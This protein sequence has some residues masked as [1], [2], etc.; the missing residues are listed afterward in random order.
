MLLRLETRPRQLR[1]CHDDHLLGRL[2]RPEQ[3][4]LPL[5]LGDL[6]L[7]AGVGELRLHRRQGLRLSEEPHFF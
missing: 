7:D 4:G 1:L 5:L 3:I 6:R 2:A